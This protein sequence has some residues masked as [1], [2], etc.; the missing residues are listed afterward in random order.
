M[1][2]Y[3]TT[4]LTE[5][6]ELYL[7]S[8]CPLLRHRGETNRKNGGNYDVFICPHRCSDRESGAYKQF[9]Q[10]IAICNAEGAEYG[11][12]AAGGESGLYRQFK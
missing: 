5:L 12:G 11:Q 3:I 6:F 10:A 9:T 1:L 7:Y 2:P 8:G 4:E